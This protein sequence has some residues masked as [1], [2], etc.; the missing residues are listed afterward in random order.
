MRIYSNNKISV[1]LLGALIVSVNLPLYAKASNC[2]SNILISSSGTN[3]SKSDANNVVRKLDGG[4]FG[5]NLEWIPFQNTIWNR[6]NNNL[7]SEVVQ[8]L[9]PFVGAV[10]RYPGGVTANIS[11]WTDLI[12]NNQS[13]P[14]RKYASW[15]DPFK[16]RFGLPEYLQ[17]LQQVDGQGWYILNLSSHYGVELSNDELGREVKELVS[18]LN[19]QHEKNGYPEISKWELGN[20]LDRGESSWLPERIIERSRVVANAIPGEVKKG[21]LVSLIEEYPAMQAKG[22]SSSSMNHQLASSLNPYLSDYSIH[23]Y[24]DGDSNPMPS[25]PWFLMS[26]CR[27]QTDIEKVAAESSYSMWVTEHA[28]VPPGAFKTPDWKALWPQTANQQA[29]ISVADTM[30]AMAKMP[31]VKGMFVHSI[32]G[33]DGPWPLFHKGSD[34]V[35]Y[36]S[37]V[38][39]ALSLLRSSMLPNVIYTQDYSTNNSDYEGGYDTRSVVMS[40]DLRKQYAVWIVNRSGNLIDYKIQI[41]T[42]SGLEVNGVLEFTMADDSKAN[43]YGM[44]VDTYKVRKTSSQLNVKFD[45]AG[46]ISMKV[47]PYSISTIRFDLNQAD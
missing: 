33:S 38:F 7:R 42:L 28:R 46:M 39:L 9:K 36:P 10:Y 2:P 30:I 24:Y 47:H 12:G 21:K 32:H 25:V 45:S 43:N 40:D 26:V 6:E 29:A 35:Y 4:F 31:A 14:T 27:A 22:I 5:F 16:N 23:L 18:Y 37:T 1:L 41:P 8:Y 3:E 15:A 13:R 20:E 44:T 11:D 19:D 34:G 17:F